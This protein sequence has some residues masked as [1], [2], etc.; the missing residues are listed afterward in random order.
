MEVFRDLPRDLQLVVLS[1]C[2]ID[3]KRACDIR[4]GRIVVPPDVSQKLN[5]LVAKQL[6]QSQEKTRGNRRLFETRDASHR[7]HTASQS[8]DAFDI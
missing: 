5:D 7:N 1:H 2:T 3:V 8:Y 4:P 6:A